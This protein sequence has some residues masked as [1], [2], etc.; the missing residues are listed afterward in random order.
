MTLSSEAQS[1]RLAKVADIPEIVAIHQAAFPGFF[2]TL[3]GPGFLERYYHLVMDFPDSVFWV[4]QGNTGIEGF[5]CGFL[6]PGQ[7]YSDMQRRRWSLLGSVLAR[8]STHPR[9]FPRLIAS[10]LQARRSSH[11]QQLEGACELSS[12]AVAP[13]AGGRGVGKG[14]VHAFIE[15]TRGKAHSIVLTTDAS[16]NDVVNRFYR[17]VGFNLEGTFER[18]KGRRLNYYRLS[19]DAQ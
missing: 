12:I 4:K 11:D 14:L 2:M 5:V 13:D 6:K 17:N 16:R 9:L 15:A 10:Y 7:F 19:L 1:Y 8:I 3:L 18:S